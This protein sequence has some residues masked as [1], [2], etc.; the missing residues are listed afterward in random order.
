MHPWK[1]EASHFPP[2]K[3]AINSHLVLSSKSERAPIL[4]IKW[5]LLT[6]LFPSI[7]LCAMLVS[8]SGLLQLPS[9]V[10]DPVVSAFSLAALRFSFG[11]LEEA[12]CVLGT[13]RKRILNPTFFPERM[14]FCLDLEL[15]IDCFS[16]HIFPLNDTSIY[17]A[18]HHDVGGNPR[19]YH[20]I[21][22]LEGFTRFHDKYVIIRESYFGY[23]RD[24]SSFGKKTSKNGS[25][26]PASWYS[27]SVYSHPFTCELS[28]VTYF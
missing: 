17:F 18:S 12:L 8:G 9:S 15:K 27:H 5:L 20:F 7:I 3:E 21:C 4:P 16:C 25:M 28:L 1:V 23:L 24:L 14:V 13:W 2:K 11:L 6:V 22:W 19:G 26:I 10:S